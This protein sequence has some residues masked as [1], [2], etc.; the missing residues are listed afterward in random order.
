M[1]GFRSHRDPSLT[2]S[3]TC[4]ASTV[5]SQLFSC[6]DWGVFRKTLLSLSSSFH[7]RRCSRSAARWAVCWL[8]GT[9]IA[10]V[11]FW[12]CSSIEYLGLGVLVWVSVHFSVSVRVY[13]K[14]MFWEDLVTTAMLMYVWQTRKIRERHKKAT[15]NHPVERLYT[16]GSGL[17]CRLTEQFHDLTRPA[18]PQ[19]RLAHVLFTTQPWR[20]LSR[21]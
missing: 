16:G 20:L 13:S 3:S 6:V 2:P 8:F 14:S 21:S 10:I 9:P 12:L 4:L 15:M 11:A 1:S 7:R 17:I 19:P 5:T 18:H